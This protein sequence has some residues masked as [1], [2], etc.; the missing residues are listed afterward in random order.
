MF[1]KPLLLSMLLATASLSLAGCGAPKSEA[2][3][4]EAAT[5]DAPAADTQVQAKTMTLEQVVASRSDEDKARDGARHPVE[6]LNFF[7]VEPGMTVAEAL[8]GGGWYSKILAGYLGSDGTLYGLNYD[9]D[10]WARF[11]FFSED[12]I[13]ER[14]AATKKFTS[15][16]TEFTDNGISSDGF[17]FSTVPASLDGTVDRVLFVRALH[18][19]NR[20]ESDA[21]T[22]TTALKATHRIL[23]DDGYVGVVQHSLPESTG[24]QS[25]DGS[26]GYLKESDVKKMFADAGFEL[27]ASSDIN[28][29]PKDQPTETDIVWRLPPSYS[30]SRDDEAKKQMMDAIGESNRMTLLFKKAN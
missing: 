7:K 26:R 29:N 12:A 10:M 16:V 27:V 8:P 6:T 30:G 25:A 4:P 17:T 19:L 2:P 14:I 1:R 5:E 11:G 3:A 18:N 23:K 20:F 24:V 9:D 13:K 15:Q 22:L 28:A 21:Q